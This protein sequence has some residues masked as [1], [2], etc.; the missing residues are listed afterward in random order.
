MAW[1][2]IYPP[3]DLRVITICMMSWFYHSL[4]YFAAPLS[5]EYLLLRQV[6]VIAQLMFCYI[7]LLVINTILLS[8]VCEIRWSFLSSGFDLCF[9][10]FRSVL[11]EINLLEWT[12]I[13][14]P[15]IFRLDMWLT[16]HFEIV[17]RIIYLDPVLLSSITFF[18]FL[19]LSV[20]IHLRNEEDPTIATLLTLPALCSCTHGT[21]N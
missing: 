3:T 17:D 20:L 7:K 15:E 21:R 12:C 14:I 9:A 8:G 2:V 11:Y 19:L 16:D 18:Y 1:H 4:S 10:S 13:I 6:P 5:F